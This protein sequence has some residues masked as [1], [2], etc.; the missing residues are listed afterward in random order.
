MLQCPQLGFHESVNHRSS[1]PYSLYRMLRT[2]LIYLSQAAWARAFVMRFALARRTALR[3]VAGEELGDALRVVAD[4]NAEGMLVTLDLLG[5]HTKDVAAARGATEAIFKVLDRIAASGLKAS[6][7]LKLTQLGLKLD[8][9]L[10]AQNM[11]RIAHHAANLGIFVRIDMEEFA[12]VDGTLALFRRT[13]AQGLDNLGAVIQSY[14]YR[15]EA[16]TRALLGE[17]ACI[18]LVKGAYKEPPHLAYPQ[19]GDVD[20]AFDRLTDL[21]LQASL[22]PKAKGKRATWP[23]LAAIGTHDEARIDYAR[24]RADELGLSLEQVEFQLLYGIRRELQ[25]QL[26]ELGYPVRIYVPFGREWYPYFMRR[27]AERPAN[28]WFFASNLIRR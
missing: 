8:T 11:E 4:L 1:H 13:R 10:C 21:M 14:L 2:L 15:S 19:K 26:V 25:K 16:D 20:A 24:Q 3:F 5:E 17:G 27:L 9:E 18:R 23:P 7:S 22:G 12:M 6:L 28:L